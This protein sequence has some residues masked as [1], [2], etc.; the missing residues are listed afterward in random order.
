MAKNEITIRKIDLPK[1]REVVLE[2]HCQLNYECASPYARLVPYADYRLKWFST[3]QPE[4][5]LSHLAQTQE[6]ER[7]IAEIWEHEG[8]TVG[9][10]WML[11]AE[12]AEYDLVIAELMDLLVV[13]AYQRQGI[14]SQMIV[15][16][17]EHA[18]ES[19][20][21]LLRSGTGIA[22]IASQELHAKCGIQTSYIQYEKAL[23]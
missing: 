3:S 13:P 22:N 8:D 10:L 23:R 5:F 12:L 19:G 11:F 9:Y 14:G 20:A 21:D 2:F 4:K 6:D 17:E 7:T 16:A 15:R 18:R 1:D